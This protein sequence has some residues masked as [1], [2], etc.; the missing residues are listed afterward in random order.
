[1]LLLALAVSI[2]T[3]TIILGETGES[4]TSACERK[5]SSLCST[6]AV[7][8]DNSTAVFK[9]VGLACGASD[10]NGTW[11]AADQPSY[12][13]GRN[14]PDFGECLGFVDNPPVSNC[15][16]SFPT[17]SRICRCGAPIE[18]SSAKTFGT[19]H[20]GITFPSATE[21]VVFT[22]LVKA[23]PASQYAAMTH[24]WSTSSAAAEAGLIVRYYV[25]G[26][27][28]AS[29]AFNP[30][31]AVGV[32]FDDS[33]APW[34]T[35][36]FGL[37]AGGD[38]KGQA[39]FH[40]LCV[41]QRYPRFPHHPPSVPSRFDCSLTPPPVNTFC[42]YICAPPYIHPL[43]ILSQQNPVPSLDPRHRPSDGGTCE[44]ELHH[45]PRRSLRQ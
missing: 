16:A 9:S 2:S 8:L 25:D 6:I 23:G 31:L 24:F 40:N 37:G 4:C 42:I 7:E 43:L 18:P 41:I 30:P 44:R 32:G 3:S 14:D 5:L 35:K 38:G 22:H 1:M 26:E 33:F 21:L 17:T 10:R 11:W 39:W 36:W 29:I 27:A 34:G 20:A 15:A 45:S 13:S 12:V 19:G 28:N